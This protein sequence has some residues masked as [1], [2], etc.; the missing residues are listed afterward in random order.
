[1]QAY[2]QQ[3]RAPAAAARQQRQKAVHARPTRRRVQQVACYA[4]SVPAGVI[5]KPVE[6]L[7]ALPL[8]T[9]VESVADDP[10]LKNPLAR[11]ERLSTGTLLHGTSICSI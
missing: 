6:A 1:M 11:M 8:P 10:L 5:E 4:V 9:R 7:E 2:L 3:L